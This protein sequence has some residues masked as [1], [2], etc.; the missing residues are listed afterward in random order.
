MSS[1]S[2]L[3]LA[4]LRNARSL[5]GIRANG[6]RQSPPVDMDMGTLGCRGRGGART[7][8]MLCHLPSTSQSLQC[9]APVLASTSE[10]LKSYQPNGFLSRD[11]G[12]RPTSNIDIYLVIDSSIQMPPSL[13]PYTSRYSMPTRWQHRNSAKLKESGRQYDPRPCH[14]SPERR[15]LVHPLCPTIS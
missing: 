2:A 3:D 1:S 8:R 12:L 11:N 5:S 15:S 14:S 4:S 13:M 6:Q 9:L 7:G 10:T